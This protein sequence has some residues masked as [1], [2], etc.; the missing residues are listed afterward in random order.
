MAIDDGSGRGGG[1]GSPAEAAGGDSRRVCLLL[2]GTGV[3][4]R[5]V[6]D[7][8]QHKSK[9]PCVALVQAPWAHAGGSSGRQCSNPNID[10]R[11][12]IHS[13]QASP[14]SSAARGRTRQ[15]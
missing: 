7:R 5:T 3:V 4:K 2:K 1:G 14:R 10:P 8:A 6:I 15:L 13:V 12:L 11:K 9:L